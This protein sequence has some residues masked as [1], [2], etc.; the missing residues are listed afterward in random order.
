MVVSSP[1]IYF[2]NRCHFIC[3]IEYFVL[4]FFTSIQAQFVRSEDDIDCSFVGG[5]CRTTDKLKSMMKQP[6]PFLKA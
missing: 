2:L 4:S 3:S 5:P 1:T 6:G